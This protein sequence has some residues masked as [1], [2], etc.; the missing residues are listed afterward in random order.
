MEMQK[1]LN[2]LGC[3]DSDLDREIAEVTQECDTLELEEGTG[4]FNYKLQIK[5]LY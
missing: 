4:S 5:H 3:A 1:K 2:I